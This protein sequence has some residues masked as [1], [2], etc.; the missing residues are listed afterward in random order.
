MDLHPVGSDNRLIGPPTIS[1]RGRVTTRRKGGGEGLHLYSFY[2][3]TVV[4]I[5]DMYIVQIYQILNIYTR[6]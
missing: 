2:T 3:K 4:F 1:T 5:N 6:K